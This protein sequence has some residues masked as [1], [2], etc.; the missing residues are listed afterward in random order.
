[1]PEIA[2]EYTEE[3]SKYE[4]TARQWTLQYASI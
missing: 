2:R 3:R 4:A 1:M